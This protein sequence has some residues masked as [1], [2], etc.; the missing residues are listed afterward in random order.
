M[1]LIL[2]RSWHDSEESQAQALEEG[3]LSMLWTHR[4][5]R[6]VDMDGMN[7]RPIG[8]ISQFLSAH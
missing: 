7:R 3:Y 5:C 8:G 4:D 2:P 1:I 6:Q